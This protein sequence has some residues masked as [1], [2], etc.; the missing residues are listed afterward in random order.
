[1]LFAS[2]I[3]S[4]ITHPVYTSCILLQRIIQKKMLKLNRPLMCLCISCN[5][6]ACVQMEESRRR[7]KNAVVN[8]TD[9]GF[10][11]ESNEIKTQAYG[12][13]RCDKALRAKGLVFK[14]DR[15]HSGFILYSHPQPPPP[16]PKVRTLCV[17]V[18]DPTLR[19]SSCVGP[20]QRDKRPG[21]SEAVPGG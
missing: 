12:R 17:C 19:S 7:E 11:G 15:T 13:A 21:W 4:M 18:C 20:A 16:P 2:I 10:E 9:L 14:M 5:T 6:V 3:R 1:V 8:L